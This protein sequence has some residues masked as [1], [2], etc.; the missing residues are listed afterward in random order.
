MGVADVA[1]NGTFA[2]ASHG[3]SVAVAAVLA[4]LYPV[5]TAL[6]ARGLLKERLRRIQLLGAGLAVAG[7]LLLAAV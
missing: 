6:M 1:A 4:S 7:T 3:G 2:T 5:V